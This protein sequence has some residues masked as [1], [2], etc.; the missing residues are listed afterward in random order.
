MMN[1][2]KRSVA[3]DII[4][5]QGDGTVQMEKGGDVS[6]SGNEQSHDNMEKIAKKMERETGH[7]RRR[8]RRDGSE[9]RW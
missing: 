7:K 8:R 1:E 6:M 2:V 4:S 5:R 3:K 9:K